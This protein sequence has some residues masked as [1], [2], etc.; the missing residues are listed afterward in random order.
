[1]GG[2][3]AAPQLLSSRTAL[4][5]DL[6]LPGLSLTL[7]NHFLSFFFILMVKFILIY[8]NLVKKE[9]RDAGAPTLHCRVGAR[10]GEEPKW[11]WG[12][13]KAGSGRGGSG[14]GGHGRCVG[15]GREWAQLECGAGTAGA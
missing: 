5:W 15:N 11:V 12:L 2:P 8:H 14:I 10:P 4:Q 6:P 3:S 13:R 7:F 9:K 1:M